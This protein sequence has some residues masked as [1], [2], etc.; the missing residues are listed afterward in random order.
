M[1]VWDETWETTEVETSLGPVGEPG[2]IAEHATGS[3]ESD[4]AR[5]RLASASPEMARALLHLHTEGTLTQTGSR[6]CP[7]CDA[8]WRERI[9]GKPYAPIHYVHCAIAAAL[10]KAGVLG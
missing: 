2:R 7:A 3:D 5:L 9:T 10:R 1:K 8:T 6:A 4:K